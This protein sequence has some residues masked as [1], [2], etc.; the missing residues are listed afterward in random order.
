MVDEQG[1]IPT[2]DQ[3]GTALADIVRC[4]VCGHSQLEHFPPEHVLEGAYGEAAS[5]DYIEE[6][7]GQR[8]T[9]RRLL[10]RLEAVSTPGRLLDVG[11]WAGFLL[12]EA[13]ARGWEPLGLEPSAFASAYARE[14]LGL[15]VRSAGL[16]DAELPAEHFRAVVMADVLE[17][18]IAPGDA[19]DRLAG[20][21]MPGGGLC[22][23]VPDMGSRL[24][25]MMGARWWSV[26]PTHMQYFTR[27]SLATL[28]RRR[29]WEMAA[30][31]TAPKAFTVRYY[32]DR[33]SGYSPPLARQL[34]ATARALRV[35]DRLWA[36][37]FGDRMLVIARRRVDNQRPTS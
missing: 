14:R 27:G 23:A 13:R 31:T 16:Y 17:H 7:I 11:C 20:V 4:R 30:V 8:E 35:A 3:F 21:T 19:L 36:P 34:V 25:R 12:A 22:I 10:A 2:T 1:L 37:D 5:E 6:E 15:D 18:L 9:A 33:L 24:A 32:L 26:L 29:G 28:L